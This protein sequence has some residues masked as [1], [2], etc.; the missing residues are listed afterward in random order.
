MARSRRYAAVTAT[1]AAAGRRIDLPIHDESDTSPDSST[2]VMV[3]TIYA[4]V[5]ATAAML[6][7]VP[8][9]AAVRHQYGQRLAAI[10]SVDH[11]LHPS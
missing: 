9:A 1:A 10:P 7:F 11:S 8:A 4:N 6:V 5:I 3:D 2:Q